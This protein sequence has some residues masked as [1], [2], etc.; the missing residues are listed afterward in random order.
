MADVAQH[1]RRRGAAAAEPLG[2]P[3]EQ[4]QLRRDKTAQDRQFLI[5]RKS[6][7]DVFPCG[8]DLM[9]KPFGGSED[10]QEL[11]KLLRKITE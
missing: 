3:V 6:V 1:L 8:D 9:S 10:I 2:F 5:R 7:Q 4:L 11:K